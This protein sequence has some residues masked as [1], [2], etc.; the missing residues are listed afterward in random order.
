MKMI[1]TLSLLLLLTAA[2]SQLL[3]WSPTFITSNTVNAV[4][5]ADAN[6]GNK[7]LLGHTAND[8]FVHIGVITTLST[9]TS[10]WKHVQTDWN[11]TDSRFKATPL[12]NNKWSYT[13]SDSLYKYFGI[14]A[15]STEKILKIAILFHAGDTKLANADG[16]DMF[17][18]VYDTGLQ[19]RITQP[20]RQPTYMPVPEPVTYAAGDAVAITAK[21]GMI[22][23]L[24]LLY[25]GSVVT[26]ATDSVISTSHTAVS[27]NNQIIVQ[28]TSGATTKYDTLSFY[29][30]TPVVTRDLP[31]GVRDGINY[32][33]DGTSVTLVLFAPNKTRV[34]VIGDFNNWTQTEAYQLYR[35]PDSNRYWITLTGLTPGQ[36]YAYQYLVDGN[37]KVAD[38]Y[39]EKILDPA[40]D[41]YIDA[42]TYPNLKPYPAGQT[43]IVSV[44]QTSKPAYT[45]Q[46]SNFTR[47]DK[48][49]LVIYELLVRDF[50]AAHNWQTVKD[51]IS[52]LKRLGVNAIEVMP[53]NEFE[54]NISWGYNPDFFFAPDKY[55]GTETALKQFI[56]ECHKQGIAVI[57]DMVMNHAFGSSPTVQ[58]YWD[59]VNNRPAADN[60]WH[61]PVATHPASVGYDFNHESAATQEL[62]ERVIE[63]WLSAYKI[64][65]FR[66]DLSKGFTQKKSGDNY[67]LWAAYDTSR[68]TTWKRYYDTMQNI[69]P[70]SYCI[71]EHFAVNSEEDTLSN[72][73]MLLWGNANYNYNQATMGYND[74]SD[75]SG[76]IYINRGF[77]NPNLVTYMESHDEERLMYKN[78]RYGDSSGSY[79][80]RNIPTG[81]ARDGMAAAFW[82]MQPAP[83]MV[84]Q[85]GELG[86]D[87]SI[88]TCEDGVTIRNDCRTSPKPIR[89]DYL[90]DPDRLALYNVYAKLFALRNYAPY[91][92]VFT[93]PKDS[94]S[95]SL[96]E[97]F[98]WEKFNSAPIDIAVIGNFDVVQQT[99]AITFS[100]TGVWYDYLK[101]SAFNI[102]T[103]TQTYT[104]QPGEYHVFVDQNPSVV[105][106]VQVLSFNGN[107]NANAINLVWTTTNE[108]NLQQFVVERSL[109]GRNFTAIGTVAARNKNSNNY[110][111]SD[112]D[113][114]AL[115]ASGDI[116]Y[117][118]KMM[119]KDGIISYS[120][121]IRILPLDNRSIIIYPNPAKTGTVYIKLNTPAS[122]KAWISIVDVAGK[123]YN[124]QT[125]QLS[126]GATKIP[127]NISSLASGIYII[128]VDGLDKRTITQRLVVEQ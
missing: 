41:P 80:I 46:V 69:V 19:T 51:S 81:L 73:G 36:E 125:T 66:W 67:D 93:A 75:F 91:L 89:W 27:G 1:F 123:V 53:F 94:I 90:S 102:T 34:A 58:L 64:D 35:T 18:P 107:R 68:I 59:P 117:R 118:L 37:L 88:N 11:T 3:T 70:G 126:N 60:P 26:T 6:Y 13:I 23:N 84:W 33:S 14:P 43:G 7:G 39:A 31:A 116:Y 104:L 44:L 77:S 98:K 42:Q 122:G 87:Y 54:G 79:N 15:N 61:N 24:S 40:N 109:D 78:E 22:A 48:R 30:N 82:A 17:V 97:N 74:G 32:S 71:L 57:M 115:N 95:Y 65:G 85:F 25:N 100:H 8:V 21:S 5:T 119:D 72:Y 108:V 110:A 101:D 16:S 128:K 29:I 63:H 9:G 92:P 114:T 103:A 76:G 86:Y 124:I 10:D 120:L 20:Y 38:M 111:L 62:V 113:V 47:P 106:P 55:Y 50:V 49:N 121:I 2:N 83:K 99:G 4:I 52:Y 45:W 96:V 112:G 56:D 12:G 127:V 28:A 105:L